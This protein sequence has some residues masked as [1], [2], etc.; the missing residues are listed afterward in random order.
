[1]TSKTLKSILW[2]VL[3]LLAQVLVLNH[4]HLFQCATPLLYI[5][6]VIGIRRNFPKWLSLTAAF[7]TGL[8]VDIFA[9]TPGVAAA[10]MTFIALIQPYLLLLFMNRESP[11][12]LKPTL[13]TLGF[14]HFIYFALPL[15]L[16]F[17]LLFFTLETFNFFNWLRWL[18]CIGG[19]TLLTLILILA[20]ENIRK[21][22]G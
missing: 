18:E 19:S 5:Y 12:D 8:I 21:N 2:Y 15:I 14:A 1:M 6:M 11:E 4:I 22:N 3:L 10:S 20:I 16:I 17:S 7:I 13:R 9:N